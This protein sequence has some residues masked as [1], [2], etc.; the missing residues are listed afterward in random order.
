MKALILAAGQGTRLRPITDDRPKVL[1]ELAGKSV[2]ERQLC[3]LHACGIEQVA[4]V[5]GYRADRF[6]GLG[7]ATFL[8]PDYATTNMVAS[9]FSATDYLDGDDDLLICYGD[10]VYQP[11]IV[12]ALLANDDPVAISADRNWRAYWELRMEDPREDAES[13][14][15]DA[16]GLV[17]ELGKPVERVEDVQGQY[18]GLIKVRRDSVPKLVDTYRAMDRDAVYDGKPFDQMYMTSFLQYLI[19]HRW[20]V[21]A[22]LVDNGWLEIDTL[23]D[24]RLYE[25]L[26]RR[27]R[28]ADYY[29]P[30]CCT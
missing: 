27:G 11:A 10:I 23:D 19:D 21:R 30:D 26:H 15:M 28:L 9:L 8:N 25:D 16:D 2:L 12:E 7:L 20:P 13:F 18:M 5:T 4:V 22:V 1:V 3:V 6:D 14:R 17:L 29:D 24:L